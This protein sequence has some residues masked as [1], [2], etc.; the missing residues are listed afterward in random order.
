[1]LLLTKKIDLGNSFF[2]LGITAL[3]LFLVPQSARAVTLVNN[4]SYT[5]A[6]FREQIENGEF[7]ELFVAEGRIGNRADNG[8]KELKINGDVVDG[9]K[10]SEET[11]FNWGNGTLY[12]FSLMYDG[13]KV[14][15]ELGGKTLT[16]TEF[17]GSVNS[18]FFRTAAQENKSNHYNKSVTLQDLVFNGESIGSVS[19][20]GGENR[21]VDYLQIK[22]ISTP[23]KLTGKTSMSW[24]G[25]KNPMR[26]NLAFQIKVGNYSSTASVPEPGTIG[27]IFIT[28]ITGVGLRKKK[29][30]N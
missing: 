20:S 12:D 25:E 5:D 4:T 3:G 19:S 28:G 2:A 18:I 1:M 17:S 10:V 26:S 22:D 14:T 7:S 24:E 23:F 9:A 13:S 29:K 8:E 15:Y 21:D 11:Q 6:D 16:T 30:G 27:A